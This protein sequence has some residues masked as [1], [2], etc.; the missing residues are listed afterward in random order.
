MI[1]TALI[2]SERE[3]IQKGRGLSRAIVYPR[4]FI[5][6]ANRQF[7]AGHP[8]Q[9]GR[10]H[11]NRR[12]LNWARTRVKRFAGNTT[13][14]RPP[15][16][17]S[18]GSHRRSHWTLDIV[19]MACCPT[20]LSGGSRFARLCLCLLLIDILFACFHC[21]FA[22]CVFSLT[23][24]EKAKQHETFISKT[25]FCLRPM[26]YSS[27]AMCQSA[28]LFLL[29]SLELHEKFEP[30]VCVRT[31]YTQFELSYILVARFERCRVQSA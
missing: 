25:N 29:R 3:F 28:V 27:Q 10:D 13:E 2:K 4:E 30:C 16:S 24:P 18:Y 26:A 7:Y 23:T 12:C 22:L 20:V 8:E 31:V 9:I 17:I 11:S 14:R 21:V 15:T 5:V 1:T 19:R 6:L